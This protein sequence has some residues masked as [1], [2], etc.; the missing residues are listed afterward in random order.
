MHIPPNPSSRLHPRTQQDQ[1]MALQKRNIAA[2]VL[3]SKQT[4]AERSKVNFNMK[5]RWRK[6]ILIIYLK[7][8][9][10]LSAKV[11]KTKLLYVTPELVSTEFFMVCAKLLVQIIYFF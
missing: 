3:N 2:E 5:F 8:L 9:S 1:I 10:D 6:V 4:K 7:I 11:P